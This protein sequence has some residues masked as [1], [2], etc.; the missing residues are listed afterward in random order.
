[1]KRFP[2]WTLVLAVAAVAVQLEPRLGQ[3]LVFDREAIRGGELWRL[4]AGNLVHFS[5]P[6]LLGDLAVLAVAGCMIEH[7]YP[8]S[9]A[10]VLVGSAILVGG[11]VWSIEP[12]IRVYGGLSGVAHGVVT[13]L[14]LSELSAASVGRRWLAAI[15]LIAL[16][17]KLAADVGADRYIAGTDPQAPIVVLATA[18]LAGACVALLIFL[19]GKVRTWRRQEA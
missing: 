16:A 12:G 7:R 8:R 15:A 2:V 19:A 3:W 13:F 4:V 1:M 11:A 17:A 5:W 6:H 10:Y 9:A 14:A 18:H